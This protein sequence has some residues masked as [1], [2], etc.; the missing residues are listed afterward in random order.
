MA[1]IVQ[2]FGGTSVADMER[3]RAVAGRVKAAVDAGDEVA[4]VLSAMP[5]RRTS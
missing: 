2:K 5:G 4:V 1:R 3:L